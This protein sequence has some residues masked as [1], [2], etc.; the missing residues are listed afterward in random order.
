[1]HKIGVRLNNND[2]I[3]YIVSAMKLFV[4]VIILL[5]MVI[6]IDRCTYDC[7]TIENYYNYYNI[8]NTDIIN[9]TPNGALNLVADTQS[10]IENL[11]YKIKMLKHKDNLMNKKSQTLIN[12]LSNIYITD[13]SG[14][15][16][17]NGWFAQYHNVIDTPSGVILAEVLGKVYGVPIICFRSGFR[18]PFLG[19]ADSPFLLPKSAFI[20]FRAMTLF[21][22]DKTGIYDFKVYTD[23]GTRLYVAKTSPDILLDEKNMKTAWN[24]C[25]DSWFDQAEV[26]ALVSEQKFRFYQNESILIRIEHFHYEVAYDATCCVK[27]RYYHDETKLYDDTIIEQDLPYNNIFCSLMWSEVPLF[28]YT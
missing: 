14:D 25:I 4:M 9:G 13:P 21:K 2:L 26:W 27:F 19:Y 16:I 22:V 18:Y 11:E 28:G 5:V 23:D 3:S 17:V 20:G 1:M 10:K 6:V 8:R 24:L 15:Y 12:K 7:M